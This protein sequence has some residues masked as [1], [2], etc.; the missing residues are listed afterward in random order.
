[1]KKL[2]F[3][4]IGLMIFASVGCTKELTGDEKTAA[5]YVKAQGYKITSYK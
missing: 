4:L 2:F 3:A 1:M 5:D